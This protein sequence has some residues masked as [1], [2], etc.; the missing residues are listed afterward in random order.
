MILMGLAF[1]SIR[2]GAHKIANQV[3]KSATKVED[4]KPITF[5]LPH[6]IQEIQT[7]AAD[8]A[9]PLPY[10]EEE[11]YIMSHLIG[12]EYGA[13]WAPDEAQQLVGLVAMNRVN[14]PD[15]SFP[16]TLKEVVFQEGQYACT[17]DGNYDEEPSEQAIEN[18]KKVLTRNTD[19]EC[20]P[21]VIF[22]SNGVN[23]D[24]I[25]YQ[26]YDEVLGRTTYFCYKNY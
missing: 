9:E 21:N 17:W 14:S 2:N 25:F 8:S 15:P 19:I 18:A 5:K 1:L 13:S 11:L 12:G 10:T 26:I 4:I 24:G 23:G 6:S 16:D 3:E 7:P 22:Q 20:P